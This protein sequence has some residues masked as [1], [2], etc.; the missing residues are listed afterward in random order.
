MG[1]TLIVFA[2]VEVFDLLFLLTH[3]KKYLLVNFLLI[4]S[5]INDFTVTFLV[6]KVT[7][8]KV[9]DLMSPPMWYSLFNS[10]TKVLQGIW[11]L[12]RR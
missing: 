3:I 9:T 5:V 10:C 2:K 8:P 7:A 1:V 12:I 6:P 4:F 11:Q